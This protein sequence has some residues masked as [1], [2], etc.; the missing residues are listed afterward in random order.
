MNIAVLGCGNMSS[1]VVELIYANNPS[2]K[3]YTYTPSFSK[4]YNLAQ[5]VQGEAL[6]TLNDFESLAIDYWLIGCKPQQVHELATSLK[7]KLNNQIIVSMLAATSCKKLSELFKTNQ[8]IRIMPNTPIG[9]GEG[10]TLTFAQEEMNKEQY[11]TFLNLLKEG[12]LLI[13]TK[14]EEQLDELTV[15]SGSGPAYLFYFAY[16]FEQKLI[17]MGYDQVLARE[18]LNQLFMG[19]SKLM[20]NSSLSLLELVGQVT[21][22]GGVTIEAINTFKSFDLESTTGHAIDNAI[23][24]SKQIA[25]ELG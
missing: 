2:V 24:K 18:L 10:I 11:Q 20:E 19:S 21:S 7:G 9:L 16:T 13:P 6:K 8:L 5:S 23:K 25:Q 17:Q 3:F 15:F 12:S 22:K 14:T 4:A 1:K